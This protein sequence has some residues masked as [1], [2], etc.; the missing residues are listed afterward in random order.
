MSR[1]EA[2]NKSTLELRV[3]GLDA[4]VGQSRRE[5]VESEPGVRTVLSPSNFGGP[6]AT[7][8]SALL[9][10]FLITIQDEVELMWPSGLGLSEA[11]FYAARYSI[12]PEVSLELLSYFGDLPAQACRIVGA[13]LCSTHVGYLER[14]KYH[15]G[16]VHRDLRYLGGSRHVPLRALDDKHEMGQA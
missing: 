9:Y 5:L 8:Q 4:P 15:Q 10:E 2:Q 3:C 11:L 13:Y 16:R 7:Q 1:A 6:P 12:I 14:L